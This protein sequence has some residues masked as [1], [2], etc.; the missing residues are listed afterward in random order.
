MRGKDPQIQQQQLIDAGR[1]KDGLKHQLE[2]HVD[3]V[4]CHK[5]QILASQLHL[6]DIRRKNE[7]LQ[8]VCTT[9]FQ[10]TCRYIFIDA[11]HWVE[12]SI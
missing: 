8:E 1:D 4:L 12:F 10:K 11:L 6:S 2:L 3:D 7:H 5:V 9:L